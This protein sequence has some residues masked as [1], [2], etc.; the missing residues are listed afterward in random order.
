MLEIS[1]SQND[2]L[3]KM[4]GVF[5]IKISRC[6][7]VLEISNSQNDDLD[8]MKGEFGVFPIVRIICERINRTLDYS[9]IMQFHC[10]KM[11]CLGIFFVIVPYRADPFLAIKL[12]FTVN[13]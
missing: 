4:D 6:S 9:Q 3:D 2:D 11:V 1:N 10:P 8:T 13:I 12:I 5:A 7:Q